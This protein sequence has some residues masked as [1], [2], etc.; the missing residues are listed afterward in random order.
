MKLSEFT[1]A[2]NN[3]SEKERQDFLETI[4]P[5][6]LKSPKFQ[7]NPVY[8]EETIEIV[9]DELDTSFD[10]RLL[11][12]ELKP[13]K[14]IAELEKVTGIYQFEEFEEHQ[15]TIN[16]RLETLEQRIVLAPEKPLETELEATPTIETTL[17]QKACAVVEYLMEEMKPNDF[18]EFVIG[19]KE[20]ITFMRDIIDEGLRVQKVSRQ[21][22]ADL[23]DRAVKLFPSIVYI[24]TSLSG[25]KT[26]LLA[27]KTSQKRTNTYGCTR[28]AP[29]GILA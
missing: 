19:R 13:I 9:K 24:K 8:R 20:L 25:N 28:T 21:L 17:D 22:K 7:T 12:S 5:D 27:L 10:T 2:Y 18:G 14:R 11:V 15:A 26:K 1:E 23:F 3:A 16:E 4:I 6:I 29:I